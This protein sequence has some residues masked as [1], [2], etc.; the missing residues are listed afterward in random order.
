[1]PTTLS[2]RAALATLAGSTVAALLPGAAGA[3][4]FYRP[5]PRFLQ[6]YSFRRRD[7]AIWKAWQLRACGFDHAAVFCAR[8]GF[9]AVTA[10]KVHAGNENLVRKLKWQGKIPQDSFLTSGRAY[11][12]RVSLGSYPPRHPAHQRH[13][14]P[15]Y[16]PAPGWH[17]TYRGY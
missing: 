13:Q 7:V 16:R 17:G 1:M 3:T 14:G 4:G 8:N 12:S 10:G 9:Y 2:R 15:R 6:V 11:V 5:A